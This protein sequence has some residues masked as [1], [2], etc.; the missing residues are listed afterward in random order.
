M[1]A[2]R[3]GVSWTSKRQ[4]RLMTTCKL[5]HLFWGKSG[6]PDGL[7]SEAWERAVS[8]GFSTVFAERVTIQLM[9]HRQGQKCRSCLVDG[10]REEGRKKGQESTRA[11]LRAWPIL[12]GLCPRDWET[13]S[14]SRTPHLQNGHEPFPASGSPAGGRNNRKNISKKAF[15]GHKFYANTKIRHVIWPVLLMVSQ[16][17]DLWF[18]K[19]VNSVRRP[20]EEGVARGP[21]VSIIIW[22]GLDSSHWTH[23]ET[24]ARLTIR[25]RMTGEGSM[26]GHIWA[27]F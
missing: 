27:E 15:C 4:P 23:H 8:A 14:E 7:G 22:S 3:C 16:F 21:Q 25:G 6:G 2:W 5:S 12:C 1:A 9:G 17:L 13:L 26:M 24:T 19:E 18:G 10:T 11:G 20:G